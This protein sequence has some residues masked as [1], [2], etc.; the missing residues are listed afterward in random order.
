[1]CGGLGGVM[2]AACMGA[3]SQGGLTIGLLPGTD[4][5]EANDYVD[6]A[7]PT[8]MGEMRNALI[9][10]ACDAIIAISGEFGTLSE[11]GFALRTS[12]PVV[13]LSTWELIRRGERSRAI[14]E[15][16]DSA[17]AVNKALERAAV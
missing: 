13:G 8:G 10:R 15:A 17:D 9:V 5:G 1:V 16:S 6:I 7:I 12:T 14:V 2:E 3:R 4:R 11:I